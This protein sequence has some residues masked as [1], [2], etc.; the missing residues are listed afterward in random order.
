MSSHILFTPRGEAAQRDELQR[1]SQERSKGL[2]A[3]RDISGA[4]RDEQ[5][6]LEQDL[7]LILLV[8]RQRLEEVHASLASGTIVI[9]AE[10]SERVAI[11]STVVLT[12]ILPTGA[13]EEAKWV[14]GGYGETRPQVGLIAYTTPLASELLGKQRGDEVEVPR[15]R[16][17]CTATVDQILP[18]SEGY[19][20]LYPT[21]SSE[22]EGEQL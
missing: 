8:N 13:Q 14:I 20:Q 21:A 5:V 17:W 16:G 15:G 19:N 22:G 4:P 6:D 10:Q 2:A 18:P 1:L 11:G 12:V 7:E 9:P 3:F